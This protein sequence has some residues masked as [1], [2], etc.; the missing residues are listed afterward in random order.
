MRDRELAAHYQETEELSLGD[1]V[2][3]CEMNLQCLAYEYTYNGRSWRGRCR[4]SAQEDDLS[5]LSATPSPTS[6]PT[7][8]PTVAPTASTGFKVMME[9]G[10]DPHGVSWYLDTDR[11]HMYTLDP[12]RH[13]WIHVGG[14]GVTLQLVLGKQHTLTMVGS[15]GNGWAGA[16]WS[17]LTTKGELLVGPKTLT[18]GFTGD[19]YF[20]VPNQSSAPM[21]TA[22]QHR[23]GGSSTNATAGWTM[24]GHASRSSKCRKAPAQETGCKQAG[25]DYFSVNGSNVRMSCPAGS[26]TLDMHYNRRAY[27]AQQLIDPIVDGWYAPQSYHSHCSHTFT[28]DRVSLTYTVR[29]YINTR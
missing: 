5:K 12:D 11:T 6:F 19:Y 1:C 20:Y 24:A 14:T 10:S 4:L 29:S 8:S 3:Q 27:A 17:L 26:S 7:Q 16:S 15:S 18:T 21:P 13:D 25:L 23:A 9:G 2:A 22:P 28:V